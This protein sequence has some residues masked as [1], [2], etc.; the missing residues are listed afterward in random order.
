MES[1]LPLWEGLKGGGGLGGLRD[2]V[3]AVP[4]GTALEVDCTC[5]QPLYHQ[6]YRLS[7]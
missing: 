2:E 3:Y 5:S 6:K 1:A 7:M 4:R